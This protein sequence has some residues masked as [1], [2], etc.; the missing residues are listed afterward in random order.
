MKEA[1]SRTITKPKIG[2]TQKLHHL[3]VVVLVSD[4][5]TERVYFPYT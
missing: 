3:K 5:H 1:S 4:N 2:S